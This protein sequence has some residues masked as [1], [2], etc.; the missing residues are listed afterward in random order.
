MLRIGSTPCGPVDGDTGLPSKRHACESNEEGSH[1][2]CHNRPSIEGSD[3]FPEPNRTYERVITIRVRRSTFGGGVAS[4]CLGGAPDG[5]VADPPDSGVVPT[6]GGVTAGRAC[7]TDEDCESNV[8]TCDVG[9]PQPWCSTECQPSADQA[10]E[11]AACGGPGTT[12]L[13]DGVS[14]HTCTRACAAGRRSEETGG[15]APNRVCTGLWIMRSDGSDRAGCYT[16]CQSDADCAQGLACNPRLGACG[17]PVD[18]AKLPD[19]APCT[20][21]E[22]CRG[23]CIATSTTA[24]APGQCLSFV[25]LARNRTC[26]DDPE[27][28]LP[29]APPGDEL[30]VCVFRGCRDT[31][32]CTPPLVCRPAATGDDACL[33]R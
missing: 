4:E 31:S 11:R 1:R 21:A 32:E 3:E 29:A 13:G 8:L 25:N 6:D 2:R 28:I 27:H 16:F 23:T 14:F 33:P 26:P 10:E 18:P 7:A 30:A 5:G 9:S 17:A 15:C 22:D 19:G 20:T 24:G 12:C